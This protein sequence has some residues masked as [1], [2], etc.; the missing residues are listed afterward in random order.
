MYLI[1]DLNLLDENEKVALIN[2]AKNYDE[3]ERF[4]DETGFEPW[5]EEFMENPDDISEADKERINSVLKEAFAKAHEM[6]LY[7]V[8]EVSEW[9]NGS[10]IRY[11]NIYEREEVKPEEKSI[12][13]DTDWNAV[14]GLDCSEPEE[15]NKNHEYDTH[16][17]IWTSKWVLVDKESGE[18]IETEIEKIYESEIVKSW[19]AEILYQYKCK[20][21][22]GIEVELEM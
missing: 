10:G 1:G 18:E 3:F 17:F 13:A 22:G 20:E 8:L 14:I 16:D 21:C 12:Y 15:W 19:M 11:T 7:K 4:A 6:K 2:R 5:M 9:V